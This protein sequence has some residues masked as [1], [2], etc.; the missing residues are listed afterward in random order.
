MNAGRYVHT[1]EQRAQ[2]FV[3]LGP[4]CD[5]ANVAPSR[6]YRGRAPE[7]MP[8]FVQMAGRV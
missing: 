1:C 3:R 6:T 8:A 5:R 7:R 4:W 2:V